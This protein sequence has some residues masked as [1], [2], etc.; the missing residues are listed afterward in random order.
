MTSTGDRSE[1]PLDKAL[2]LLAPVIYDRRRLRVQDRTPSPV[3]QDLRIALAETESRWAD[4]HFQQRSPV[5][6]SRWSQAGWGCARP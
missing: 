6:L 2:L 4:E 5:P 1:Y 3:S